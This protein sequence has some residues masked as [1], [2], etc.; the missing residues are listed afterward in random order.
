MGQ[1]DSLVICPECD[2]QVNNV[3]DFMQV[4]LPIKPKANRIFYN[5]V[6]FESPLQYSYG[7]AE[8]FSSW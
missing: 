2:S 7:R 6:K 3:E 8:A 5:Y 1:F 4:T